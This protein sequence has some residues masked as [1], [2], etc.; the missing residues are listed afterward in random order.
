MTDRS[1]GMGCVVAY[2]L[3]TLVVL[4]LAAAWLLFDDVIAQHLAWT[5]LATSA[6]AAT[7]TI[8]CYFVNANKLLRAAWEGGRESVLPF[9]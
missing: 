3:W 5:A 4:L 6:A 7:A 1:V 9:R 2:G 8:R